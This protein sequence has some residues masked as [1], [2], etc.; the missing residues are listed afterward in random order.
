ML[1]PLVNVHLDSAR[2]RH[3]INRIRSRI[4]G[5]YDLTHAKNV[6]KLHL[7]SQRHVSA[8]MWTDTLGYTTPIMSQKGSRC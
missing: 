4:L 3:F 6:I 2:I 1:T 5:F 7:L 8:H